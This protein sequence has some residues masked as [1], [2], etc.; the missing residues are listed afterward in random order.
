MTR[1][2]EPLAL[3]TCVIGAWLSLG[4]ALYLTL[5]PFEFG[6]MGLEEAWSLYRD[7]SLQGPGTSGRAQFMANVMM[8]MPL[9]FFWMAWLTHG[10]D[11]LVWHL[12][13]LALVALLGLAT[14]ATAEFLQIWLPYRY[15]AG[16]DIAGNFLGAVAGALMWWGLRRPLLHWRGQLAGPNRVIVPAVLIAYALLY[17]AIGLAPFDL[18]LS[19]AEWSQRLG[20]SAWGLWVATGAC[21]SGLRCISELGLTL[22]ASVPVGILLAYGGLR[23]R[24]PANGAV[25][26]ILAALLAI[27]L[28][29]LNLATLSGI[30][31]G[32]SA[33][34]RGAGFVTGI[35]LHAY[36][37]P[38]QVMQA[39]Q[40]AAIPLLVVAAPLYGAALLVLNH[41][42][43]PYH[44]NPAAISAQWAQLNLW[45]F[46]YHYFV[47]ET[48]ALRSAAL[49]VAMYLPLGALI[50]LAQIRRP[51][52]PRQLQWLAAL[53]GLLVALLME[54]GKL[55]VVGLRPD[56]ASLILATAA[57]WGMATALHFLTRLATE[58]STTS[59]TRTRPPGSA[60][61][62]AGRSTVINEPARRE[63]ERDELQ[64]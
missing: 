24:P 27:L 34:L 4:F 17:V 19:S 60:P 48:V 61:V 13:A 9:G 38:L 23:R 37:S 6:E 11:R 1:R 52:H 14:T 54:G 5:L 28:E 3:W 16:A 8:F 42:L 20:P 39:L 2:R 63:H 40:R 53:G 59:C 12:G 49:H 55:L 45:P 35:L 44:W 31:E 57:A 47:G 25:L 32:R 64:F 46:Y 7:M 30:A 43:G 29:A 26:V 36:L 18:V 62:T 15:P 22:V 50:W 51:L 10:R 41:D 33:V 58:A 21:T 56:P